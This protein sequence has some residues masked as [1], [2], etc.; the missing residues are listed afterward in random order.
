MGGVDRVEPTITPDELYH[1]YIKQCRPVVIK[2]GLLDNWPAQQRWSRENLIERYGSLPLKV[3]RGP[4]PGG[5][6]HDGETIGEEPG[7]EPDIEDRQIAADN[8]HEDTH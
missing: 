3:A 8:E 2:K 5:R 6:K 4:Q 7:L 1:K